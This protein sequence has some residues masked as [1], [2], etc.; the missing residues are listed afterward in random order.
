MTE[1]LAKHPTGS[2]TSSGVSDDGALVMC[3][4]SFVERISD[5]MQFVQTC[6]APKHIKI[7]AEE[8]G[9][10]SNVLL[11]KARADEEWSRCHA[12]Q[13]ARKANSK[14]TPLQTKTTTS[15]HTKDELTEIVADGF[16]KGLLRVDA[17]SQKSRNTKVRAIQEEMLLQQGHKAV[18]VARIHNRDA[19]DAE[20]RKES[21]R[22]SNDHNKRKKKPK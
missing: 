9:S 11:T 13:T 19:N 3:P 16:E 10:Y 17:L 20:I 21:Q 22:I 5:V 12:R 14:S 2:F 4:V 7:L 15:G 18:G 8:I 1:K 6:A